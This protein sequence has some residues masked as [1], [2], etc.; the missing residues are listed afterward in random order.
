MSPR[1]ILRR[2]VEQAELKVL[3]AQHYFGYGISRAESRPPGLFSFCN[4]EHPLLPDL[5]WEFKPGKV[6]VD[7][8]LQGK[9]PS[10]GCDWT[11]RPSPDVWH[12]SPD[13]GRIW[14]RQFFGAIPYR[15]GN[16]YGDVRITW[17]P[18]R[19]QQ[20]I[21][22]S[23]IARTAGPEASK[24]AV[25]MLETQLLSWVEANPPLTGVHYISS[26]E[27]ALRIL[28]V[29]HAV[30]MVRDKLQQPDMVWG[31][32]LKMVDS[33]A[34]VIASRLSL[35]SSAGNHTIAECV[36]LIYAG[37]LFPEF[38]QSRR[39]INSAL[40]LLQKEIDRQILPDGGG[41]EQAIWY[42]M[43]ITDLCGLAIMLLRHHGQ[44]VPPAMESAVSRAK[45]YL[46]SFSG[47]PEGLPAI[48]DSDNGYA[49]SRY[50]RISWDRQPVVSLCRTFDDSGQTYICDPESGPDIRVILDHGPLGMP[51]LYGHGHA[52]ALSL[53]LRAG[54]HDLLIDPGTYTYNGDP[55]LRQYFRSTRSHNTVCIDGADQ[56]RQTGAFMWAAPYKSRLLRRETRPDGNLQLLARLD[57]D[58]DCGRIVH[59][60]GLVYSREGSLLVWD[61]I[62]GPGMHEIE[63]NWHSAVPII[64]KGNGFLLHCAKVD[65][66]LSVNG[67]GDQAWHGPETHIVDSRYSRCYGKMQPT[68]VIR[69]RINGNLPV[70]FIT[71]IRWSG[72]PDNNS[73]TDREVETLRRWAQ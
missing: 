54:Q 69:C 56:A 42:L 53:I 47:S 45:N 1:E 22:F 13:T 71:Y 23:L 10:L 18:S 36:G 5:H 68:Q 48:G 26:M 35:H 52:D 39:W 73:M 59:W 21:I 24:N 57:S 6:E 46:C 50:L 17:E 43:F 41:V 67:I 34:S 61:R 60:R 66:D 38:K 64:D 8:F 72:D 20:L 14:P 19:L 11:W 28:S 37:L 63:L 31:S 62:E 44:H 3:Q 15:P 32:L 25:T 7:E 55:R 65:F 51:P 4:S 30:D 40:G 9:W 49:L 33:H 58:Y 12:E 29:C 16:P 27:C 70:E 2:L